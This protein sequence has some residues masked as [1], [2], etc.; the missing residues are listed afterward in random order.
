MR[1]RHDVVSACGVMRYV[2]RACVVMN[3]DEV[4][5]E[6]GDTNAQGGTATNTR[7]TQR[8]TRKR[9]NDDEPD[10]DDEVVPVQDAIEGPDWCR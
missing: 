3:G 9:R 1:V 5:E 7:T 10:E 4:A 6:R 8:M 2:V